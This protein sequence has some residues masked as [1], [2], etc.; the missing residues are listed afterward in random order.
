[1]EKEHIN[2]QSSRSNKKFVPGTDKL[3]KILHHPKDTKF[4]GTARDNTLNTDASVGPSKKASVEEKDR[5]STEISW[6][7]LITSGAPVADKYQNKISW[8]FRS[9]RCNDA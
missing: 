7:I 8:Q 2:I 6:L 3:K 5:G 4:Y 1:M 9:Q